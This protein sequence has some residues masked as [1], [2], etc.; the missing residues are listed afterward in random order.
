MDEPD[1]LTAL[2]D[3][4]SAGIDGVV[5]VG[6]EHRDGFGSGGVMVAL[7]LTQPVAEVADRL[8]EAHGPPELGEDGPPWLRGRRWVR[9]HE[10]GRHLRGVMLLLLAGTDVRPPFVAADRVP[11]GA[12]GFLLVDRFHAV[13]GS[14]AGPTRAEAPPPR[15]PRRRGVLGRLRR[16]LGRR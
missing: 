1:E 5:D 12:T 13:R 15:P 10:D 14:A 16:L 4:A 6:L 2:S 7:A 3:L 11:D 9:H 8:T